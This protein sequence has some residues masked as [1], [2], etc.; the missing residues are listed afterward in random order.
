M[1][2][3]LHS[4]SYENKIIY[5]LFFVFAIDILCLAINLFN[6]FPNSYTWSELFIKYT[7]NTYIRRGLIGSILYSL[8]AYVDIH[9]LWVIFVTAIHI[10]F[11][12][13]VYNFFKPVLTPFFITAFIFSP[14][15]FSFIVRDKYIYGRKDIFFLLLISL[16]IFLL[17]KKCINKN[18]SKINNYITYSLI[19]LCYI[20]SF[21]IHEMTIFFVIAPAI[22][23]IKCDRN[24]SIS[25]ILIVS[26]ILISSLIV[27]FSSLGT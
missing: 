25:S 8:A 9:I 23:F 21:M 26:F 19:L 20:L 2:L 7:D 5:A 1:S 10:I 17:V 3:P 27:G 11:F 18:N 15:I 14:G 16:M 24:N 6:V 22:L 13:F 4:S 12:F